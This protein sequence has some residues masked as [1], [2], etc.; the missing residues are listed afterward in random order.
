M[1]IGFCIGL[2]EGTAWDQWLSIRPITTGKAALA[3]ADHFWSAVD[4]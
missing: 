2:Q 4:L 1:K 3:M